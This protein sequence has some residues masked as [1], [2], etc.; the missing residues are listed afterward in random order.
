VF[1]VSWVNLLDIVYPIGAIYFSRD[2]ISPASIIG[3]SWTQIQGAVLGA[4]GESIS[5]GYG[6]DKT[7][8]IDQMPK[9]KHSVKWSSDPDDEKAVEFNSQDYPSRH[10]NAGDIKRWTS[11][12]KISMSSEGLVVLPTGGGQEYFPYYFGVYIWY[13]TA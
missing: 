7:I 12:V 4:V 10:F 11:E 13:R 6:G 1:I 9:H 3:G 5:N 2:S 8:S